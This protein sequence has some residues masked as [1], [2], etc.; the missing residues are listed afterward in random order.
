MP[1]REPPH[2]TAPTSATYHL[3]RRPLLTAGVGRR[4][5]ASVLTARLDPRLAE[6]GAAPVVR[7]NSLFLEQNR[8][9]LAGWESPA[10]S[11]AKARVFAESLSL[12]VPAQCPPPPRHRAYLQRLKSAPAP[13]GGHPHHRQPQSETHCGHW[14]GIG[15]G[16]R[17]AG[18]QAIELNRLTPCLPMAER[19]GGRTEEEPAGDRVHGLHGHPSAGGRK[20]QPQLPKPA[21]FAPS[22]PPAVLATGAGS[23][24][25]FQPDIDI[26][27]LSMSR[28]LLLSSA[29]D[30]APRAAL[31]RPCRRPGGPAGISLASRR[32]SPT[33]R[34]VVRL[35][36]VA[37]AVTMVGVGLAAP[38]PQVSCGS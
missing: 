37:P 13:P 35:P 23:T 10:S 34:H 1:A 20:A 3:G 21:S 33:H 24:A 2:G 38:W 27:P 29:A 8:A 31:D 26:E 18:A 6:Q 22:P 30:S 28:M 32:P 12:W 11:M 17:A 15:A 14:G 19:S 16:D 7:S 4:R 36:D 5:A 25:S 9:R